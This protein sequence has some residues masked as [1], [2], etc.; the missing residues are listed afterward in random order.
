MI[1]I[2]IMN[3]TIDAI[4]VYFLGKLQKVFV[5]LTQILTHNPLP[6]D[7]NTHFFCYFS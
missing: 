4:T 5:N 3:E 1:K 7:F 6:V 2:F